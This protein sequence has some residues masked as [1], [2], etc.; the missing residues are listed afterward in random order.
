MEKEIG[1]ADTQKH[2]FILDTVSSNGKVD[3]NEQFLSAE[4]RKE[5][6]YNYALFGLNSQGSTAN[7][8][9]I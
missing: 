7:K 2:S 4:K 1:D 6:D 3:Q 8:C 5:I 9:I